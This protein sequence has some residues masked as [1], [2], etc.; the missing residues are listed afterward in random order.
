MDPKEAIPPAEA[1]PRD[2]QS[3]VR[4]LYGGLLYAQHYSRDPF[5]SMSARWP[6]ALIDS[7]H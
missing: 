3:E 6:L 4:Q 7:S 2:V 5:Y 1:N